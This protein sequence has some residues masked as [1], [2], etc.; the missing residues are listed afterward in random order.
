MYS[1]ATEKGVLYVFSTSGLL[2]LLPGRRGMNQL[3]THELFPKFFCCDLRC[4]LLIEQL[5]WIEW[6]LLSSIHI[7]PCLN[8][9]L[10]LTENWRSSRVLSGRIKKHGLGY[11]EYLIKVISIPMFFDTVWH[12]PVFGLCLKEIFQII[13]ALNLIVCL[14]HAFSVKT[15]SRTMQRRQLKR[16]STE[17]VCLFIFQSKQY[18]YLY[19]ENKWN[20]LIHWCIALRFIFI[21]SPSK[22]SMFQ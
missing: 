12:N 5:S 1:L 19:S 8:F 9:H 15:S 7:Y 18:G 4:N 22:D 10:D 3:S 14:M 11:P 16:L 20:L 13:S 17:L 6:M 2:R 21:V